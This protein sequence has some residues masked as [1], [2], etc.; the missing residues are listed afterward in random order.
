MR[1]GGLVDSP[2]EKNGVDILQKKNNIKPFFC[3]LQEFLRRPRSLTAAFVQASSTIAVH[4]VQPRGLTA[5][6]HIMNPMVELAT[7]KAAVV[8]DLGRLSNSRM[9]VH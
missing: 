5:M 2:T 6:V 9:L 4:N 1:G 7:T 8:R 3:I